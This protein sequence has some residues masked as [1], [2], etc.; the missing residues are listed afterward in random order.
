MLKRKTIVLL[1][2][3]LA[4]AFLV[5][6][7]FAAYAVFDGADPFGFHGSMGN[8][9]VD[10]TQYVTLRWGETTSLTS[11]GNLKVN[12]NRKAGVVSLKSSVNYEYGI[13]SVTMTDATTAVKEENAPKM[14]DYLNIYVFDGNQELNEGALPSATLLTSISKNTG[15]TTSGAKTVSVTVPGTPA[16]HELSIFVC[17]DNDASPYTDALAED[18]VYVEVDYSPRSSDIATDTTVYASKNGDWS[19][20]YAYAWV[21]EKVNAKYPGVEMI[22]VFD[23]VYQISIPSNMEYVI[24]NNGLNG[25]GNQ[26]ANIE[27]SGFSVDK[28]YWDG[29]SWE[30]KPEPAE[31]NVITATIDDQSIALNDIKSPESTDIAQYR[32]RLNQ[33]QVIKFENNGAPIHFYH[34]VEATELVEAHAEDDGT[35]YTAAAD[36]LYNFYYNSEKKMYVEALPDVAY[37]L[38]GTHNDWTASSDARL[39]GT[40]DSNHFVSNAVELKA[41]EEIK[42]NDGASA[43]FGNAEVYEGCGYTITEGGNVRV[44]EAGTYIINFYVN[45]NQGNHVILAK[46]SA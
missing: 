44:T 22:K 15:K 6:G 13:F 39:N 43:W 46:Q 26:T 19:K 17:L 21:G 42:V 10:D 16:G 18:K 38:V 9:D 33:G 34:W 1:S 23:D 41:G 12:E 20:M 3:V 35:S 27:L 36:G 24:F 2:S 29:D 5:G 14:L 37:Y 7:A 25:E 11:L 40:E 28:P 4:S 32:I 45:S 31:V 30:A 8:L